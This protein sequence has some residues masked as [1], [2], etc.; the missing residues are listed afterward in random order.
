[1]RVKGL[2][3][4]VRRNEA[5]SAVFLVAFALLTQPLAMIV[6]FVPLLFVDPAHTPWYQWGGYGVRY[7]PL[8]ALAALA[9]FLVPMRRH[10][11]AVRKEAGFRPADR[12]AEPRHH[13]LVEP[14]AIATGLP[15]R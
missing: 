4:W 10:V 9:Y 7:A 6:A 12:G 8:V 2:F 15:P 1:M 3:G 11:G 5:R 14:L 13:D